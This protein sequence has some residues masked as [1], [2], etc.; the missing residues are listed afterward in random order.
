METI[1]LSI[2]AQV[3]V[4]TIFMKSPVVLI[5]WYVRVLYVVSSSML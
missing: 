5:S 4:G 1:Y 2:S 3:S